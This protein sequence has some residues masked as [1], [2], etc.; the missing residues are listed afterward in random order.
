[1][2]KKVSKQKGAILD[3]TKTTK[4]RHNHGSCSTTRAWFRCILAKKSL[5]LQQGTSNAPH[6]N[7]GSSWASVGRLVAQLAFTAS[8][9]GIVLFFLQYASWSE[10]LLGGGP[11]IVLQSR[12]ISQ[13]YHT[14][15]E[16]MHPYILRYR[17]YI[18]L[19]YPIHSTF[20]II[21][22]I[23]NYYAFI[24]VLSSHLVLLLLLDV[25]LT[26]ISYNTWN[27]ARK[28]FAM[29]TVARIGRGKH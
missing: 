26:Y 12:G 5:Q 16:D 11:F 27:P 8:K 13:I 18:T 20:D 19:V 22:Y 2:Y 23:S 29:W 21:I 6:L 17:G 1:M 7:Q 4:R 14:Y 9:F 3:G 24:P 28:T 25:T 15:S 10:S